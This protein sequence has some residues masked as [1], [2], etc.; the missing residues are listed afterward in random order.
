M[1]L[2]VPCNGCE[3]GVLQM[4]GTILSI[5]QNAHELYDGEDDGA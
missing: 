3:R 2:L 1:I 4:D 5:R